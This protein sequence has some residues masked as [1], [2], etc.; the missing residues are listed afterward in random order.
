[1]KRGLLS[2][3]IAA[4]VAAS[5]SCGSSTVPTRSAPQVLFDAEEYAPYSEPGSGAVSG[6]SFLKTRGGDVKYGAGERVTIEPVTTYSRDWVAKVSWQSRPPHP[7]IDPYRRETIA[8]AEG[9]FAFEGLP[10][11]EWMIITKVT[12]EV[13]FTR[14]R[15]STTG[16]PV[17]AVIELA[18]GEEKSVVLQRKG[19]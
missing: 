4:C 3:V 12:W 5:V 8:D 18:D 6:Q 16:G 7:A 2:W 10:P 15:T 19:G 9:R 11:G 17:G 14:F 13:P 1:M